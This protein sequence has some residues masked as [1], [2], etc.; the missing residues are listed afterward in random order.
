MSA[1]VTRK[2]IGHLIETEVEVVDPDGDRVRVTIFDDRIRLTTYNGVEGKGFNDAV[3]TD[4]W[5]GPDL[6]TVLTEL[7]EVVRRVDRT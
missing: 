5:F 4:I 2:S 3:D 6:E 7:L 1:K